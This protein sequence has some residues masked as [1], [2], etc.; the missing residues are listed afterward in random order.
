MRAVSIFKTAVHSSPDR[1]ERLDSFGERQELCNP[2]LQHNMSAES[3]Q[4]QLV[5]YWVAGLL[6]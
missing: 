6:C 5:P 1:I 4:R 2:E 3:A